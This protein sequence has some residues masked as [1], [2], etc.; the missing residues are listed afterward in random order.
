MDGHTALLTT[1]REAFE[2]GEWQRAH[3][4]LTAVRAQTEL[5]TADLGLLGSAAW[6]A[7]EVKESLVISEE[8]YH[9]LQD[10]DDPAGA[11][12]KA[13]SLGLLWFIRGDVVIASGW[14]NRARRILRDLPECA[15]HGYLLYLEA[16]LTL[17]ANDF[18]PA[19]ATAARLQE[20]GRR[21][22]AP[23]LTSFALV[24]TGLADVHDGDTDAGFAQL[25]EA[26]LPVLAG[27]V[28]PE[29]AGALLCSAIDLCHSLMD[30]PR[31]ERWV[32]L[33]E[34]WCEGRATV[35]FTGVC[36]V[37]RAELLLEHGSWAR[38][39]QE[40]QD[41]AAALTG[42]DV[43]VAA[44]AHYCL[45]ELRRLRGDLEGAEADY[46]RAHQLGRDPLPGLALLRLRHGR[47][48]VAASVL[49]AALATTRDPLARAPLLAARVE[50]VLAAE[51]PRGVTPYLQELTTI[52][53]DHLSPG[54]RAQA[55]RWHGA[56][57]LA[58][59]RHA[60]AVG[61]LREALARWQE[62]D[63][64]YRA[65]QVRLDLARAYDALGDHD[66]A[67]REHD[68]AVAV[69][70]QLGARVPRAGDDVSLDGLTPRELEVVR[71]VAEGR[72]NREVARSLHISER[73]VARHL[74]NVY[75]KTDVS[76]R[77]AAVAWARERGLV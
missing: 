62:M 58:R 29:W 59:G 66:T 27:E 76:T 54:W 77:T 34:R 74:A 24:L 63:A 64:P 60:E 35:L 43:G 14:V 19:H 21:L 36:R 37:H 33:T 2:R 31:A 45:G 22:R 57:L 20:M 12:M 75:V 15:E 71:A 42:L 1:A 68:E 61:V 9:R 55:A 46:R 53:D 39:E 69:L 40:L 41:A 72:T 50:V 7:G 49:D 48:A 30:L 32:T 51:D 11:A 38:A 73:T 13:L 70:E 18:R 26:M 23:E 67:R 47:P 44:A 52:A 3:R 25:D 4:D 65:A 16:S 10:D 28:A 8:V 5:S 6:W 17:A 56:V